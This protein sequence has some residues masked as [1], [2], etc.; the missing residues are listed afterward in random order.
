MVVR[1]EPDGHEFQPSGPR[2]S[3]GGVGPDELNLLV[4]TLDTTCADRIGAYGYD[5][6]TAE[7]E[8]RKELEAYSDAVKASF[9]LA[10]L[11]EKQGNQPAQ[12]AALKQAVEETPNFS[13]GKLFLSKAY[14]DAGINFPEAIALARDS[15]S[16]HLRPDLAP[17]A[18]FVLADLYNRVGRAQDAAREVALGQGRR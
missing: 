5:P 9:N 16:L 8:Y 1:R 12:I 11:Y 18:H 15:L 14:L 3:D 10:R 6:Q 17:L 7:A 4:I 13:E 2:T